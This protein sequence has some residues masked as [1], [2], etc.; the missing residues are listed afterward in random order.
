[1]AKREQMIVYSYPISN[2]DDFLIYELTFVVIHSHKHLFPLQFPFLCLYY[3]SCFQIISILDT[4]IIQSSEG[5]MNDMVFVL[6]LNFIQASE[7]G[8]CCALE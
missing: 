2:Y 1:M 5:S 7:V 4:Q 8:F 6:L 3:F